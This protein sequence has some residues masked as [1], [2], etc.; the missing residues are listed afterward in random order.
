[1][2][3]GHFESRRLEQ[4]SNT[5][6]GVAMT[7]LAYL[8]ACLVLFVTPGP[9][10]SLT[11]ART[12]GSGRR[13]GIVTVLGT[14]L[15][16]LIHTLAAVLGTAGTLLHHRARF[17]D[18]PTLVRQRDVARELGRILHRPALLPTPTFALRAVLG[19]Q[20]DLLLHGQRAVS[21]KLPRFEHR[22]ITA[23]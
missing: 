10:M 21:T 23:R 16:T 19:E 17:A 3:N 6:F 8:A 7:L 18:A 11:L 14:S 15:G 13:A 1:M 4:L 20:A 5:I 22:Q 12:I 9:D 2:T